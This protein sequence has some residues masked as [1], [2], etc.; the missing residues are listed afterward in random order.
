M[1]SNRR[2]NVFRA[3]IV[4]VLLTIALAV[5]GLSLAED[6]PGGGSGSLLGVRILGVE[7]GQL[8]RLGIDPQQGAEGEG[9]LAD[10]ADG[11]LVR[12]RAEGVAFEVLGRAAVFSSDDVADRGQCTR[13]NDK[14]VTVDCSG[15]WYE[16]LVTLKGCDIEGARV[17]E[18]RYSLVF[19]TNQ[20]TGKLCPVCYGQLDVELY[21]TYGSVVLNS[22]KPACCNNTGAQAVGEEGLAAGP[23]VL[24]GSTHEFDG[25]LV[26]AVWTVRM[27]NPCGYGN[28]ADF[29]LDSWEITVYYADPIPTPTHTMTVGPSQTPLPIATPSI[30]Q[31]PFPMVTPSTTHTPFPIITP[32]HTPSPTPSATPAP[33]ADLVADSLEVTQGVQDLLNSVDLVANKNTYVRFHVHSVSG[34]HPTWAILVIERG[35]N[36]TTIL[37]VNAGGPVINVQ[38]SPDRAVLDHAF[39]FELPDGYKDGTVTLTA[40]MNP[41]LPVHDP[42]ETTYANNSATTTVTFESVDPLNLVIYRVGYELDGTIYTP[43]PYHRVML[44]DWLRRAYPVSSI[45]VWSRY[46][47]YGEAELKSDGSGNL[48]RPNCNKV[49]RNLRTKRR[50]D[51]NHGAGIPSGARYYGMVDDGGGFMRGCARGIPSKIASGP[52]GTGNFGW[53]FDGSYGDWYGGHELGHTYGR[54]H[55]AFC[56]AGGGASYPYSMGRISPVLSG[57]AAIYGFDI[58]TWEIYGPTWTD[59]MTYC[60]FEWLSDFTYE[61]IMSYLQTRATVASAEGLKMYPADRLLV[62]GSIDP[63]TQEAELDPLFII[64]DAGEPE[65]STPGDYAIVLRDAGGTELARYPFT[66]EPMEYGPTL[67]GI[68]ADDAAGEL[69]IDELMLYVAGT[70]RVEIESQG[71]VLAQVNAG[72]SSPTVSIIYPNGGETLTGNP[73]NVSWSASDP[74]D[75]PLFFHVEYSRDDGATWEM[76]ALDLAATS[77]SLEASDVGSAT[78]GRF[79]VWVSDGIHTTSD[80]S[81]DSFSVPNHEPTVEIVEP[82]SGVTVAISQTLTLRGMAYDA[83]TGSMPREQLAWVSSL[84]GML[85]SGD[86][87]STAA[88]TAGAHTITFRADDGDGGVAEDSVDVTVVS[89]FRQ[90]PPV[91]DQ[92]MAGPSLI[93]FR[94]A[95]G[96]TRALLSIDN[97]NIGNAISWDAAVGR[98]WVQLSATAG[99]T[100]DQVTASFDGAG[101]SLGRH[102][103]TITVTSEDLPGES[104]VIQVEAMAYYCLDLPIVFRQ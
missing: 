28:C 78:R 101:L 6:E 34:I 19:L 58:S 45:N 31:T 38:P 48:R 72:L 88:L 67:P 9:L 91:P 54:H 21:N 60:D 2:P 61:G 5:V 90:L 94:P 22:S 30:T 81:D 65:P 87:L 79:R 49:N 29:V 82:E 1:R 4:G 92:L 77:V 20:A 98:S 95:E 75:D 96:Q 85:D 55:A 18:V 42:A 57:D 37:P 102:T 32:T 74:D 3:V 46:Y 44:E 84:D 97:L 53:D 43:L 50:W 14:N 7:R 66:P 76:L 33:V 56:G 24:E 64:P 52:T 63:L 39:L 68:P 103:T 69:A 59:V 36:S 40:H 16:S 93:W 27:R 11:Q 70:T 8:E 51:L 73:I 80:A 26:P 25:D 62:T 89:D 71:T 47:F 86:G 13:T 83:D 104:V 41:N 99:T 35:T 100:P 23:C 10:V 17:T 15:Q 12:L